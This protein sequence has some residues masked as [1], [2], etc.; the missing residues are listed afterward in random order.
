MSIAKGLGSGVI[1][2]SNVVIGSGWNVLVSQKPC[3]NTGFKTASSPQSSKSG[4]MLIPGL[5]VVVA[6]LNLS[7]ILWR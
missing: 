2:G 4:L 7:M 3:S 5:L 1:V 6:L